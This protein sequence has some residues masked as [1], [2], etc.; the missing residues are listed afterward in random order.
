MRIGNAKLAF[1][2]LGILLL[3]LANPFIGLLTGVNLVYAQERSSVEATAE[4]RTL[5]VRI[6]RPLPMVYEFFGE[7]RNLES[8]GART[9]QVYT[10]FTRQMDCRRA[11]WDY[12]SALHAKKQVRCCGSLHST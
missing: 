9:R 4:S 8:V 10:A 2:V 5:S 3:I 1:Q 12:R 6:N 7:P 11:G